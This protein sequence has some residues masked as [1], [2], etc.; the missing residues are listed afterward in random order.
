VRY[1]RKPVTETWWFWTGVTVAVAG[2]SVGLYFLLREET[3][4][5]TTTLEQD[6]YT[7]TLDPAGVEA[8]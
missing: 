7:I 6:S 5:T 8:R 3:V 4:T 1:E 2:G